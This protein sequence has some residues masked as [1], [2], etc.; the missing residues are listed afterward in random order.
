MPRFQVLRRVDAFV[1]YVADVEGESAEDAAAKAS[2]NEAS[3]AWMKRGVSHFD[4]RMF[5][6]LDELGAEISA[7]QQGDY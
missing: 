4:A 3:F 7:T 1:D 2:A 6:T 5:V